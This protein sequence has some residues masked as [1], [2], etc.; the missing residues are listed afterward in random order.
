LINFVELAAALRALLPRLYGEHVGAV[1]DSMNTRGQ[2]GGSVA[3]AVTGFLLLA[4]GNA[5]N[6]AFYLSTLIDAP[7]GVC[8]M[9]IDPLTRVD[10]DR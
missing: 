1:S 2:L 4:S 6:A 9:L 5:W 3:P 8:W 7:G 10:L